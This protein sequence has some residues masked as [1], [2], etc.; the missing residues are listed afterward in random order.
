MQNNRLIQTCG[1]VAVALML[2][3]CASKP[4]SGDAAPKAMSV[5]EISRQYKQ[6]SKLVDKGHAVQKKADEKIKAAELERQEGDAMVSRG[7]TLMAE[8]EQAFRDASR[9][10]SRE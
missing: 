1:V 3:A 10:K 6:G 5:E 4:V 2:G 9:A 8:S 7:K